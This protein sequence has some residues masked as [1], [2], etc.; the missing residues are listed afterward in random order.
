MRDEVMGYIS[1]LPSSERLLAE[2]IYQ[3][4]TQRQSII[5][6]TVYEAGQ[7]ELAREFDLT[8]HFQAKLVK[9]F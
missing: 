3:G 9:M 2:F 7:L 8:K 6:H 4:H 1:R 5:R